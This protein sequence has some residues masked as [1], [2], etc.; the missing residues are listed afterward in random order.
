MEI[1]GDKDAEEKYK[2]ANKM[3]KEKLLADAISVENS[4]EEINANAIKDMIVTI[5]FKVF[6]LKIE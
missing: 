2:M 6:V 4:S 5:E 1:S 3:F